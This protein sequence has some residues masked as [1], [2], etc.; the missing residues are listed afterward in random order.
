[1]CAVNHPSH[2]PSRG[3]T[4]MFRHTA[5]P[6]RYV[7]T[8]L[9]RNCLGFSATR[10]FFVHSNKELL[11]I[12][13]LLPSFPFLH[14]HVFITCFV[15]LTRIVPAPTLPLVQPCTPY[16]EEL[17]TSR[18]PTND[19]FWSRKHAHKSAPLRLYYCRGP[20]PVSYTHLTLPTI[21]SV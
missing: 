5:P 8:V 19:S 18:G 4:L 12:P 13:F 9:S 1:M 10:T 15:H 3:T 14:F 20:T 17:S 16:T 2:K 21:Y 7:T 11:R 6:R